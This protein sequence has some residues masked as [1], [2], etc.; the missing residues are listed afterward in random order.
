M[1]LK[2]LE[3]V[4]LGNIDSLYTDRMGGNHNYGMRLHSNSIAHTYANQ[5]MARIQTPLVIHLI[6]PI[7]EQFQVL[8]GSHALC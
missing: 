3:A 1:C 5:S 6:L 7:D 4:Q 2:L 8:M